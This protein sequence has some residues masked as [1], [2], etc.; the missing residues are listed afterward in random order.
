MK[1]NLKHPETNMVKTVKVGFSWTVF[2]FSFLPPLFRGDWKWGI[3]IFLAASFTFGFTGLIFMFIY[4]KIYLNE[5]LEK[6]YVAVDDLS[7]TI[8]KDRG[9]IAS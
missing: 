9:F 5:L 8:L 6:E 1:V 7:E 3:I 2:F 4:N